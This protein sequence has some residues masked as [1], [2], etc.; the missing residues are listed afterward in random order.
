MQCIQLNY[1]NKLLS[2]FD[3]GGEAGVSFHS[4][5]AMRRDLKVFK[6]IFFSS[7][8]HLPSLS[9]YKNEFFTCLCL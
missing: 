6:E 1:L 7:L 2:D 9:A 4:S 3:I 8:F 5:L